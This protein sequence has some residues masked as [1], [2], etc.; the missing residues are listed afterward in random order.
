MRVRYLKNG[1]GEIPATTGVVDADFEIIEDEEADKTKS[2][3]LILFILLLLL[4]WIYN[5]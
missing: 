4:V 3:S 5:A 2:G 1:N